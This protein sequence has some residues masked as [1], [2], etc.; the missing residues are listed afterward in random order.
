MDVK[1]FHS[2]NIL[3]IVVYPTERVYSLLK[4]A[5]TML[6]SCY[7]KVRCVSPRVCIG[8]VIVDQG[9]CLEMKIRV[10]ACNNEY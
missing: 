7:I 6:R 5:G 1:A 2:V 8:I 4:S 3:V 9:I 10:A